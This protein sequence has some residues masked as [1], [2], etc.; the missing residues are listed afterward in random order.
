VY[1]IHKIGGNRLITT[2]TI[3]DV[4]NVIE[5]SSEIYDVKRQG[6]ES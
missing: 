4:D 3:A 2:P 1:Y 6:G 5:I